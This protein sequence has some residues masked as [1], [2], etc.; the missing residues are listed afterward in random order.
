MKK[1]SAICLMIAIL[2]DCFGIN[3]AFSAQKEYVYLK[4]TFNNLS[5]CSP[6]AKGN[7]IAVDASSVLF[8]RASGNT[9]DF[10]LDINNFSYETESIVYEFDV[11]PENKT[12]SF[13]FCFKDADGNF[14]DAVKLS[15]TTV[16]ASADSGLKADIP[17]GKWNRISVVF[18]TGSEKYSLYVNGSRVSYKKYYFIN[19]T[20]ADISNA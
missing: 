17:T 6:A 7:T 3:A 13:V 18:D 16:Y 2:F 14:F 20:S 15:G 5:Y 10:H 12:S 8:E 1:Y 11:Y 9:N 4:K 19:V